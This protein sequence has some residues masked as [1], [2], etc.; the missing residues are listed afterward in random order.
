MDNYITGKIIRIIYESPT[1]LYKVGI[2]KVRETDIE[3]LNEYVNKVI[4]FT[5]SFTELNSD[6][7]YTFHGSLV[8]HPKYGVQFNTLTYEVVEPKTTDSIVAYLSSG[9]IFE[10]SFTR[11][12][13]NNFELQTVTVQ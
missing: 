10:Y 1:T 2:F 11:Y 4:S 5:G 9:I 8:N 3:E 6:L 12:H 13:Y 7:E